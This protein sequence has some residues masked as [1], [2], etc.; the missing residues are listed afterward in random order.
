MSE[1]RPPPK[2]VDKEFHW[3]VL[4]IR[5]LVWPA[6]WINGWWYVLSE[7]NPTSPA[8]MF[9]RGWRWGAVAKPPKELRG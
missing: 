5:R 3:L 8:E 9:A 1:T 6:Q 4:G 2:H 7:D